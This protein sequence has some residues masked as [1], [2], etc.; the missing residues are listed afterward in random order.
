M[1]V[2][3]LCPLYVHFDTQITQRPRVLPFGYGDRF[4]PRRYH[5]AAVRDDTSNVGPLPY[6]QSG[7]PNCTGGLRSVAGD[8]GSDQL[9]GDGACVDILDMRQIEG[10]W[11]LNALR[12]NLDAVFELNG[13]G[14]GGRR[15]VLQ[16]HDWLTECV[17]R[18]TLNKRPSMASYERRYGNALSL[19]WPCVPRSRPVAFTNSSHDLPGFHRFS[20]TYCARVCWCVCNCCSTVLSRVTWLV[21]FLLFRGIEITRLL[22]KQ[23]GS[24]VIS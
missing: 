21:L 16:L 14:G 6:R 23:K 15:R 17:C 22:P 24:L 10:Y 9:D 7:P 4:I 2:C 20:R 3:K 5:T 11:R 1:Y 12:D 13:G 18:R 19:D 8:A